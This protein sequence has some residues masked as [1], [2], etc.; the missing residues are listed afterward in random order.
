MATPITNAAKARNKQLAAIHVLASK[1]LHLDRDTYVALLHRVGGVAS[2]A[3]LDQRGRVKVLNEL[4]RLTGEG[5]QQMRNAVNLPDAPQN[6]REEIAGMV[7]K[8]GALLAESGK[9]WNYAH[10][11]A[12]RMFKVHRVEWLRAD[13]LHKLVAA[14]QISANRNARANRSK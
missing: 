12:K 13:Q 7:G 14:L 2:S 3:D 10:G 1:R 6:V 5:Q 9:S 11:T 8:V 4:R